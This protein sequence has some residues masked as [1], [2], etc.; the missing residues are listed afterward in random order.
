MELANM[1]ALLGAGLA[2]S[3]ALGRSDQ[4]HPGYHRSTLLVVMGLFAG[5]SIVGGG[6]GAWAILTGVRT[7]AAVLAWVGYAVWMTERAGPG[8]VV[9]LLLS[10]LSLVAVVLA[11]PA[12]S[13]GFPAPL[14]TIDVIASGL[15][16]GTALGAM[17]LG[18]FYLNAPTM[19]IDALYRA[20]D[21]GLVAT[22]VRGLT[23][24]AWLTLS[25]RA[26]VGLWPTSGAAE[27]LAFAGLRVGMGVVGAGILFLMA[28]RC[29]FWKNTQAAT[30]ILYVGV[31][32]TL[33]G[34]TIATVLA[35]Q[36]GVPI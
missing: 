30:G 9:G 32:F 4:L 6:Q 22:V 34:E 16:I 24:I 19:P 5:A 35:R 28:R 1:A 18:H 20:I 31:C 13:S 36:T 25:N 11:A 2:W 12:A 27:W 17:L 26:H 15:L 3:L 14:S 8:R 10:G 7:L 23:T 21:V 29:L 33:T